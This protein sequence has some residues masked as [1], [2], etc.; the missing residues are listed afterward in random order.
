[1]RQQAAIACML[2]AALIPA[3]FAIIDVT[4]VQLTPYQQVAAGLQ[5]TELPPKLQDLFLTVSH[6]SG[7]NLIGFSLGLLVLVLVPF[8]RGEGWADW[9]ILGIEIPV[10]LAAAFVLY[11]AASKTG[12]AFPWFGPLIN[13]VLVIV[14]FLLSTNRRAGRFTAKP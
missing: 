13:L 2:I 8:R 9:A 7:I 5:W 14:G 4:S 3:V 12:A 1:M 6:L 11:N 10:A